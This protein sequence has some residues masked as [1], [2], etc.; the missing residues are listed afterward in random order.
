MHYLYSS[1]TYGIVFNHLFSVIAYYL[2]LSYVPKRILVVY[3]LIDLGDHTR[4]ILLKA[5]FSGVVPLGYPVYSTDLGMESRLLLA[6]H[7]LCSAC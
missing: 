2:S 5:L 7:V 3:L 6:K 1:H 4:N